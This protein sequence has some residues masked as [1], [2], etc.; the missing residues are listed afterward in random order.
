MNELPD[1]SISKTTRT[2]QK[3]YNIHGY[4]M[5]VPAPILWGQPYAFFSIVRRHRLCRDMSKSFCRAMDGN[6]KRHIGGQK[7]MPMH[8]FTDVFVFDD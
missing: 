4:C 2:P 6:G 3:N 5:N 1:F 7:Y 8:C